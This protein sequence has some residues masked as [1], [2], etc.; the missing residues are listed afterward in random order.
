MS[1]IYFEATTDS[2]GRLVVPKKFKRWFNEP[3]IVRL[4][5]ASNMLHI[6]KDSEGEVLDGRRRLALGR[7][8]NILVEVRDTN[9]QSKHSYSICYLFSALRC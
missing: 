7:F 2:R 5:D 1:V 4:D 6:T 9:L 8:E 3:V